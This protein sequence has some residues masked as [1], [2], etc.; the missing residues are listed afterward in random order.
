MDSI[1]SRNRLQTE[2]ET[3]TLSGRSILDGSIKKKKYS[4]ESLDLW[5]GDTRRIRYSW[6]IVF[7]EMNAPT[8]RYQNLVLMTYFVFCVFLFVWLSRV[9]VRVCVWIELDPF[10]KHRFILELCNCS[11]GTHVISN[12]DLHDSNYSGCLLVYFISLT[13]GQSPLL[14]PSP[15]Q[16]P[17]RWNS[18]QEH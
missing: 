15:T 13:T 17:V 11:Q 18:M 8:Q 10:L 12:T 14:L 2:K 3:L 4:Q 1:L 9:G 6:E 5:M 16:W 7:D